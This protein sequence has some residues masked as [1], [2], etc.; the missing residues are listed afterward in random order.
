[1]FGEAHLRHILSEYLFYF[2]E[3]RAHQGVGN[4]RLRRFG[5]KEPPKELAEGLIVCRQRLGGLLKHF[6]RQAA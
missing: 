1:M 4:T 6:Y 5:E 3:E 2:N